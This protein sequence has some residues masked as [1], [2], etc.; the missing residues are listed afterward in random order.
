MA[1]KIRLAKK[2]RKKLA[3]FDIVVANS[4]A[5][6]DG[7]FIEKLGVY[8]PTTHP[9]SVELDVESAFQWVM[10]GA[11]PTDTVKSILQKNG[12]L[13]RKHLQ[14]GVNKG[15]ITQEAADKKLAEWLQS[16]EAAVEKAKA[17]LSNKKVSDKKSRLEAESK[18]NQAIAE[19]VKAKKIVA[20]NPVV[21]AALAE[22][23]PAAEATEES[24]PAAEESAE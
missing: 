20:E 7:K 8:N 18:V 9:A 24:A 14:I 12:I 6:R 23:T 3:I 19:K 11:Q 13:F 22:E 16:K 2:G 17:D 15:A 4:K 10:D 5:P 21:A 1:V